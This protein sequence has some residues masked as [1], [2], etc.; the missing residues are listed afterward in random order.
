MTDDKITAPTPAETEAEATP[1]LQKRP[2]NNQGRNNLRPDLFDEDEYS[3][4]EY[5]ELLGMYEESIQDIQEGQI[6]TGHI[7][8]VDENVVVLDVGFKSEGA[9]PLDE[10]KPTDSLEVGAEIDVFLENLEDADGRVVLS[11]KKADFFK[12]W[13]KIRIAYDNGTIVQG[14]LARKIKGGVIVDLFGVD[15]FLPGSQIALRRVPDID[16]LI[17]QTM[18]FKIIKLNKRRRNIVVSRR[19]ILEQIREQKRG[20]LLEEI[21]VGQVRKGVV[22]NI[23][24]FGAFI[25]LG[26]ADGLLHITD[27][28]WGRVGH[29]SEL[30]TIGDEL[31][32]KILDLD[33][34]NNRISLGLKQL[35]PYPWEN[36]SQKYAVGSRIQG[37]VVSITNYGAFVELEK[38]VEGLVHIS[39]MSWTRHI[40]HPSKV[41]SIGDIIEAVVL[42]VNEE[43]EK[44]SLGMKQIEE[45]PWDG[46]AE[47][48]PPGTVIAGKVRNL[49]SFGAFVEIEEG[50]DG[51]VHISDMSWT[52][53]IHHPSEVVRKGETVKVQVLNIDTENK[54]IS[55]SIKDLQENPWQDLGQKYSVGVE[56]EGK[57]V[58]LLDKGV[59]VDLGGDV[60]GF[61]PISQLGYRNLE[62]P[63]DKFR[64]GDLL[65]LKVIESDPDSRRIVLSV[66]DIPSHRERGEEEP[67][68]PAESLDGDAPQGE[69]STQM[70]DALAEAQ[71]EVG[72]GKSSE[73]AEEAA[74]RESVE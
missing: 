8:R 71:V 50:I 39:E 24:D 5:E 23:T 35:Q 49:T 15:A 63:A 41:V 53:R 58:R 42:N 46:L 52:R 69:Q 21:A 22:K 43:E 9:V 72:A 51:L 17:G 73:A 34:Q 10:F 2:Q 13:D 70:A 48:Y 59:V 26:G 67:I 36:V 65:I 20:K 68:E 27:M 12:V 19:M 60:E 4:D 62:N 28:S 6:V 32:I 74:D 25:D 30:V 33:L 31:E 57:V 56:S 37:K 44:I 1:T 38:G 61:V 55:L 54:R 66:I 45:D 16:A 47:K 3:I 40:K 11:K 18:E 29:P 7:L 64:E 14:R